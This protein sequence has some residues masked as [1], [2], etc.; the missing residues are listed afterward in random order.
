M[1]NL[2]IC[3]KTKIIQSISE[4]TCP[5]MTTFPNLSKIHQEISEI[6]LSEGQTTEDETKKIVIKW[7]TVCVL[8]C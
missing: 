4:N 5:D 2:K 8:G 3:K 7:F 6:Q 1:E